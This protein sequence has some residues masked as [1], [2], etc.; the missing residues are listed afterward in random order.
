MPPAIDGLQLALRN[1]LNAW[2]DALVTDRSCATVNTMSLDVRQ[3]DYNQ[4][5]N[6][7]S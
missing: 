1:G 4:A 3:I 7:A 2:K 6:K 5:G